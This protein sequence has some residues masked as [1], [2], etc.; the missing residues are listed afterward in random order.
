MAK[1]KMEQLVEK[2]MTELKGTVAGDSLAAAVKKGRTDDVF[3]LALETYAKGG[4]KTSGRRN[5]PFHTAEAEFPIH[6]FV[7]AGQ[8]SKAKDGLDP[9]ADI[10][11]QNYGKDGNM[12]LKP[13]AKK[14]EGEGTEAKPE[15]ATVAKIEDAPKASK[16]SRRRSKP[17][18]TTP[19][20]AE[21]GKDEAE[22]SA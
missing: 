22:Q 20:V 7:I 11:R 5:S 13:R 2:L 1:T 19:V 21:Q 10:D 3:K 14:V 15:E 17:A 4:T 18:T 9:W 6:D 8:A 16:R 12:P